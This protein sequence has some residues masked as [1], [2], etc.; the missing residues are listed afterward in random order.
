[1]L[2]GYAAHVQHLNVALTLK[3]KFLPNFYVLLLIQLFIS[4]MFSSIIPPHFRVW[5][6]ITGGFIEYRI[7]NVSAN[8]RGGEW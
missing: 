2:F 1:M 5:T 6:L 8:H 4:V 3:L 7:W